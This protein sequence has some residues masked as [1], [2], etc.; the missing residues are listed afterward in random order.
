VGDA[1]ANEEKSAGVDPLGVRLVANS[2]AGVVIRDGFFSAGGGAGVGKT[3]P[4]GTA[5]RGTRHMR[6][7]RIFTGVRGAAAILHVHVGFICTR[8]A[9]PAV[10]AM[11]AGIAIKER[12]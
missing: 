11:H 5:R 12:R 1:G 7:L 10:H 2:D 9:F 4:S 3:G 6:N 8:V